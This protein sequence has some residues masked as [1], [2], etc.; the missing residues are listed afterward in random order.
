MTA[1]FHQSSSQPHG[2]SIP[3]PAPLVKRPSQSS[4]RPNIPYPEI[5]ST[6]SILS[7]S[8]SSMSSPLTPTTHQNPNQI[9]SPYFMVIRED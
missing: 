1:H 4:L 6:S 8:S 2:S 3:L 9:P 7:T 5:E